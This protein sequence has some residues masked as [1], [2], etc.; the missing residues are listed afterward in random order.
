MHLEKPPEE[1]IFA[2]TEEYVEYTSAGA[3]RQGCGRAIARS[4]Y[5]EDVHLHN[6]ACVWG[7]FFDRQTFRW[8]YEDDHATT[9]KAHCTGEAGKRARLMA[10]AH[11]S[12]VAQ[13]PATTCTTAAD[14]AISTGGGSGKSIAAPQSVMF[15]AGE[16]LPTALLD[17]ARLE[18]AV[19]QERAHQRE[20]VLDE[21]K[22]KYNSMTTTAC[23]TT[24]E[25]ME[26]YHRVKKRSDD[27]MTA[28]FAA[29]AETATDE[30]A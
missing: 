28:I 19:A 30:E 7:S 24:I 17:G 29:E 27:P 15:G 1:L 22:R 25:D 12:S 16:D 9:R 14:R 26:A 18:A 3:L 6:H 8:G 21:R 13:Q 4:K 10:A 20:S 11:Q 23:Q 2:Q 5:E